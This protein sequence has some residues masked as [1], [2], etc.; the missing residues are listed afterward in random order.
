[1]GAYLNGQKVSTLFDVILGQYN[2]DVVNTQEGTQE[3]YVNDGT[4]RTSGRSIINPN[5]PVSKFNYRGVDIPLHILD[6]QG[7][8]N[9]KVVD[10]DGT[11]L[12]EHYLNS[13]AKFY[14][15]AVPTH[16]GLRFIDWS[17]PVE[18]IENSITVEN[19]DIVIGPTYTTLSGMNEFTV[20][21]NQVTGLSVNLNLD[22]IKDWGDGFTNDLLSH[23]YSQPGSYI[24]KCSGNQ[25]TS[26]AIHGLFSQS[27]GAPNYY[28]TEI[29]LAN[30]ATINAYAFNYL[31]SL[32]K[33]ILSN[34]IT[35]IENNAFRECSRLETIIF[36]KSID[37]IAELICDGCHSLSNIV[38]PDTI[39]SINSS[40]FSNCEV[41][42]YICLP[43]NLNYIGLNAFNSC[44]SLK[45]ITIPESVMTLGDG[46]FT[47]CYALEDVHILNGVQNLTSFNGCKN[48]RSIDIPLY[49]SNIGSFNG[50]EN[51]KEI[52][53]PNSVTN[54]GINTFSGCTS[55]LN[56]DFSAF[57]TPP[58]LDDINAFRGINH[59]AKI[60]VKD[61]IALENFKIANNWSNYAD[62][63]YVK[64]MQNNNQNIN[65]GM[66]GGNVSWGGLI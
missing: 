11:I 64:N 14:L 43:F 46:I 52:I 35:S 26:S 61:N 5:T 54:I 53:V 62:Y 4:A 23:T 1:M 3:L 21:L 50:C 8:Y 25:I 66:N 17:S 59:L 7:T 22:G 10:F 65:S 32:N 49:V 28:V 63:M 16:D 18:I 30:I 48:L 24:I 20:E 45:R 12:R 34:S 60:W 58:I 38:L 37:N 39:N 41:L 13:G 57:D 47:N 44:Y 55:L 9:V 40:A 2:I 56:Y 29:K 27:A 31:R 15:P 33:V 36:P 42:E 6:P 19:S 51:L